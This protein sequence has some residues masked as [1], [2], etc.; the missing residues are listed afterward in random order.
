MFIHHLSSV[1]H[2]HYN[3]DEEEEDYSGNARRNGFP[4]RHELVQGLHFG[5]DAAVVIILPAYP[6]VRSIPLFSDRRTRTTN[7][8]LYN[9]MENNRL[10]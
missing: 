5:E 7:N 3:F 9:A 1:V 4:R 8:V 2:R 10:K 6:A